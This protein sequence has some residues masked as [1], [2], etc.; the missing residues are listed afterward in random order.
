ME[1]VGLVGAGRPQLWA[2]GGLEAPFS[3]SCLERQ[4]GLIPALCTFPVLSPSTL[5]TEV[6]TME[7][8]STSNTAASSAEHL[9]PQYLVT[10]KYKESLGLSMAP[11]VTQVSEDLHKSLTEN[12]PDDGPRHHSSKAEAT[13]R[14]KPR[15]TEPSQSLGKQRPSQRPSITEATKGPKPRKNRPAL[16]PRQ[17]LRRAKAVQ[18]QNWKPR[19]NSNSQKTSSLLSNIAVIISSSNEAQDQS[20]VPSKAD[21]ISSYNDSTATSST[22]TDSLRLSIHLSKPKY[23]KDQSPSHNKEEVS[24]TSNNY[25]AP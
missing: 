22:N 19:T 9:L 4:T 10:T 5:E 18:A 2:R 17:R 16:S 13:Q 1:E 25:A 7:Y 23:S 11:N 12:I 20:P 14:P 8:K 24:P 6:S 3:Q 15:K 21:D